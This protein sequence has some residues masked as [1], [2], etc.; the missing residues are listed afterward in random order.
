MRDFALLV[1]RILLVAIFPISGYY[2]IIQWP[3]IANLVDKAG[4][5]F[6]NYLAMLGTA[7][8]FVLPLLIVLGLFT[9]CA[10]FGLIVYVLVATYLGHPIWRIPPEAFFGQLMSFMKNIA[11]IGGLLM[12]M[13]VGPGRLA[14]QPSRDD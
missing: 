4:W 1:S 8:E 5:P 6:A 9:R 12:L 3:G 13:A 11:M 14:I 10:A 2:K 7:A